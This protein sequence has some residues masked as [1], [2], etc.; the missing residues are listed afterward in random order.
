MTYDPTGPAPA[1]P[2]DVIAAALD[3][4]WI[5]TPLGDTFSTTEAATRVADYLTGYGWTIT[6]TVPVPTRASLYGL[7]VLILA[8]LVATI[9]TAA[10][11]HWIWAS[12]AALGG[13]LL[14][15]ELHTDARHRARHARS[16]RA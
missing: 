6:R 11:G 14:A 16:T 3:D 12:A 8:C 2:G 9:I 7:A 10:A 5:T 4:Y 15:A 13:L 1:T